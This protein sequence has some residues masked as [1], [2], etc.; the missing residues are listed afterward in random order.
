MA[1]YSVIKLVYSC[2]FQ[3]NWTTLH[4][5]F[6]NPFPN[7]E[8]ERPVYL[9]LPSRAG[10]KVKQCKEVF[11]IRRSLYGL[12][13]TA[14]IWNKLLFQILELCGLR[15]MDTAAWVFI[16]KKAIVLCYVD[17]LLLFAADESTLNT[18]YRKLGK[19]F[20]VMDLE[21][22]TRLFGL[23]ISCDPVGSIFF[24]QEQLLNRLLAETGMDASKPI[25][26][27]VL[28][29]VLS[30]SNDSELREVDEH[31]KFLGITASLMY[32]ANRTKP[33]LL[34]ATSMLASNLHAPERLHM[35]AVER[36][37]RYLNGLKRND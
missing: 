20:P 4:V 18:L 26:S 7:G 24:S 6:E 27:P 21:K 14:T 23:N 30:Q 9:E 19:R 2:T 12:R 36:I 37:L 17:D 33:N 8:Q 1:A 28:E 34:V 16:G 5:G 15:E 35:V 31:A 22:S 10:L 3:R 13:D 25:G 32:I 29:A 11:R